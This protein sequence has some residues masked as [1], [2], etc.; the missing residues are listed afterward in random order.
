M[1]SKRPSRPRPFRFIATGAVVGFIVFGIY[2]YLGPHRDPGYGITYDVGST[3]GYMSI[4]G[5][6]VGALVGAV[7]VAL[8]SYRR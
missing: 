7:V 1:S 2:S 4:L 5:L 3:L 6:C 8:L